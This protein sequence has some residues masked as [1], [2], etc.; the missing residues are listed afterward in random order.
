[1]KAKTC[2]TGL[3]AVLLTTCLLAW[4]EALA[5]SAG[6][7][8]P[9]IAHWSF[10]NDTGATV[11]DSGPN[12]LHGEIT[13]ETPDKLTH[14]PGR[15]GQALNLA[16]DHTAKILVK[17]SAKLDLKPPF[18]I[19]AWI[20]RTGEKPSSMEIFCHGVDSGKVGYRLRYGWRMLFFVFGDGENLITV[21][22]PQHAIEN[23]KW[24]HVAVV[25]DRSMVR[26]FIN[27][28]QV[29]EQAVTSAPAPYIREAV[30]G[31]Y[32]GRAD[33]YQFVGL[34]DELYLVGKAL[35]GEEL[36]KLAEP[37]KE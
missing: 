3:V 18:T 32:V 34:I 15:V 37:A 13:G 20:K 27:A 14:A 2:V 4:P 31:N 6:E 16:A 11:T 25:H 23:D 29:A 7:G 26:L 5:E 35:S 12:A 36:F 33:A 10:D 28:E 8:L 1:M 9:I 22:S 30:I 17:H 19:A 21:Q 24:R